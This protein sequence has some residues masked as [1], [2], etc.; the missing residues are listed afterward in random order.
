MALDGSDIF[1]VTTNRRPDVFPDW[2]P[3]P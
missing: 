2:Q 1:R 3:L